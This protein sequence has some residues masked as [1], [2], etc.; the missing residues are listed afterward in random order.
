MT[1]AV[2]VS[3]AGASAL[4]ALGRSGRGA[5]LSSHMAGFYCRL[6]DGSLLLIHNQDTGVIPFGLG[7]APFPG[8]QGWKAL[9]PGTPATVSHTDSCL[10]VGEFC[11]LY[12]QAVTPR[13]VFPWEKTGPEISR[14]RSGLAGA[15]NSFADPARQGI[16]ASYLLRRETLF[17]GQKPHP[18]LDDL[19]ENAV[20]E[21]LQGIL[22]CCLAGPDTEPTDP[23]AG[24][25]A[26]VTALIGL[27]PGLTP[28]GDDILCGLFAAGFILGGPFPCRALTRL[29]K[30]MAPAAALSATG[31][32]TSQS[33]AFLRGA[34]T[35]ERFG[36]L[37]AVIAA[38]Y[39]GSAPER[40]KAFAAALSVGHSS[41]SG[42]ILG[43]LLALELSVRN[44]SAI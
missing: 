1:Y 36:M 14:L 2:P 31:L 5:V 17:A 25:A 41:G 15:V 16:A 33:V 6:D 11:F 19:W 12:G 27:G 18:P 23:G 39:A 22:A 37:D 42:L 21:P 28:L 43:V 35:G 32:T 9:E 29:T 8:L 13:T 44:P 3:L 20:W 24:A 40:E 38:V 4:K 34:A 7:C 10:R 26:L 30:T